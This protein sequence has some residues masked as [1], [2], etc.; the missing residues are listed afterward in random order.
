MEWHFR[1]VDA[2]QA[3]SARR[4]FVSFLRKSCT[5]D[6]DY[7]G[8]ELIFGEL[9]TNVVLHAQGPIEISVRAKPGGVLML[10]VC[11]RGPRFS[12]AATLPPVSRQGGRGLYIVSR[13]A[14]TVAVEHNGGG[15]RVSVVLPV[16]AAG[17]R[18]G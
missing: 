3:L 15:N 4:P 14:A 16:R 9:V 10:H 7:H 5:P 1:A 17:A 6:S 18:K 2:S 11:D 8:A 12:V 13:L